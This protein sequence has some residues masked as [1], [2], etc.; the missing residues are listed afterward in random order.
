MKLNGG[1]PVILCSKCRKIIKY[2][3]DFTEEERNYINS[4]KRLKAQYCAECEFED[5]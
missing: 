4:K 1:N 5:D 3:S 2:F